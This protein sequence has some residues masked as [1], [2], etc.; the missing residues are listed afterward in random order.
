MKN[1]YMYWLGPQTEVVADETIAIKAVLNADVKRVELETECE[2]LVKSGANGDRLKEAGSI[3]AIPTP[4]PDIHHPLLKLKSHS[5][6]PRSL[7]SPTTNTPLLKLK[8]HSPKPHPAPTFLRST[9]NWRQWEPIPQNP[10]LVEYSPVSASRGRCSNDP[11][12]TSREDGE[13]ECP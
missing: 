1:T 10:K 5:P 7:F 13:W 11:P 6:K 2:T 4:L 8:S 9:R 12:T 3:L